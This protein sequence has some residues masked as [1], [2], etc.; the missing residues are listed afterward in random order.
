M[1]GNIDDLLTLV[2]NYKEVQCCN[3]NTNNECKNLLIENNL[4][5]NILHLNIRSLNKHYDE[6]ILMLNSIETKNVD[7][8]VLSETWQVSD[9]KNFGIPDYQIY[10]NNA[11]FNKNDGL[12]I[13]IKNN[14]SPKIEYTKINEITF[15]RIEFQYNKKTI[16]IIGV[17]RPPSANSYQFLDD[18]ETLIKQNK[19]Q[20]IEIIIGDININI[21][22]KQNNI[23]QSYLNI[24]S[25]HGY[26]SCINKPTRTENNSNTIIDHIFIKYNNYSV[27]K[28]KSIIYET[29]ITDHYTI[30]LNLNLDSKIK[31]ENKSKNTYYIIDYKKL[32]ELISQENW[33]D[34]YKN[35]NVE[36]ITNLLIR[37]I[38]NSIDKSKKFINKKTTYKI[39]PWITEGI[40]I[41]INKRNKLKKQLILN[42]NLTLL[43]NYKNYRN[44]LNK[45]IKKAKQ[46]YYS[47]KIIEAKNNV[48]KIWE[49][50][51]DAGNN[52]REQKNT[53]ILDKHGMII[54][55]NEDKANIFNN[56]FTQVGLDMASKIN[57]N[58]YVK[59]NN[60][61]VCNSILPSK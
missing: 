32:Q 29:T 58:N 54:S 46:S 9:I 43:N 30:I 36:E 25:T 11:Y 15:T 3:C 21:L 13:Y 17:Y 44:T 31:I 12:I 45:T 6:L 10:Y 20:S 35:S 53:N 51:K 55:R 41:S 5:I 14:I 38:Q 40:I 52:V 57:I 37:K 7:I 18:L 28:I 19:K 59:E 60:Q 23:T 34:I 49:I 48:K 4:G 1:N 39:K 22:D 56:Y 50:I 16:G 8:I 42:N 26:I 2:E 47:T 33:D 27:D 24:L 61:T